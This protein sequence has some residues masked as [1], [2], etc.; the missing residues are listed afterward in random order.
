MGTYYAALCNPPLE[1][2]EL[3]NREDPAIILQ[4][5][6]EYLE[7]GANAIK[8]NTFALAQIAQE[9]GIDEALDLLEK[10][11]GLAQEAIGEE[12][13]YLFCDF[14]PADGDAAGVL[15]HYIRLADRFI[16]QGGK[17]FL[18]ETFTDDNIIRPV[19]AHIRKTLPEAYIIASFAVGPDGFTT[20]GVYG[21]SLV[22]NL[23]DENLVDAAGFNCVSGPLH[24]SQLAQEMDRGRYCLSVMPNAG[25]PSIQGGRTVYNSSPDYFAQHMVDLFEKGVPILGGCCGTDPSYIQKTAQRLQ[26]GANGFSLPVASIAVEEK[27]PGHGKKTSPNLFAKKLMEGKRVIAVELDSPLD[28][29]IEKYMAC[30]RQLKEHGADIITIA[31]CPVARSRMDSSIVAC[32]LRRELGIDALPHLTCRDRNLNATRALLLGLSAEEVHNVLIITG[33]PIPT[34]QRDEV[35]S[36]YNWNARRLMAYIHQLGEELLK[37]PFFI[38]GALNVNAKNFEAELRKAEDKVKSGAAA[39]FTQ[40]IMTPAAIDNLRRAKERLDVKILGGIMPI[41][42]HRNAQFIASEIQ[43]MA[44][45]AHTI[46]RFRDLSKEDCA[47]LGTQLAIDIAR[48]IQ[49]DIDGYYLITPFSRTDIIA[50]VMQEIQTWT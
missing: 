42:S 18:F 43:G 35:K 34:A 16:A 44:I 2:C 37:T 9:R 50:T 48:Q 10:A 41:V 33:D 20:A 14:G 26:E 40:P 25:Y 8:T 47:K 6:R 1:Y 24:L 15:P 28:G 36:V 17:H 46:E 32:K 7:A 30:A 4:I 38:G 5:H 21:K 29:D 31:D 27:K 19:A 11:Y 22:S 12:G 3:A 23:L 45:E 39:L 49:G 13:A